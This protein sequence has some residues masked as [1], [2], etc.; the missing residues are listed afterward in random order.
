[1][2]QANVTNITNVK[3]ANLRPKYKDLADW[4]KDTNNV[5]IGRKGIVFIEGKR[6]PTMDSVWHNPYKISENTDRKTVIQKYREYIIKKIK[7]EHLENELEKL[8]GK[9]L[10]CWC[11]PEACHGDVLIEILNNK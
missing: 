8:R 4:I 5:Y 3:V 6:Y 11:K 7:D 10:G 2:Q 9:T 1:M